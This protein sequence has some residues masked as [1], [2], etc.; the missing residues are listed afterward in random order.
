MLSSSS[1]LKG[2]TESCVSRAWLA[3][4]S[5]AAV[6]LPDLRFVSLV[7]RIQLTWRTPNL[8]EPWQNADEWALSP[9]HRHSLG[10]GFLEYTCDKPLATTNFAKRLRLSLQARLDNFGNEEHHL[11]CIS[12]QA[13]ETPFRSF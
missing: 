8:V 4:P 13:Y 6:M 3:A 1:A 11:H 9:P 10:R 5:R 12:M 7:R 2:D